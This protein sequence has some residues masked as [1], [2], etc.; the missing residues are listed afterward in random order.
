VSS[1]FEIE[2]EITLHALEHR[3]PIAEVPVSYRSRPPGS[4]SK[5]RTFRD[6]I[7]VLA[8]IVRLYKD[9]RPLQF[10]GLPGLLLFL[11]GIAVGLVVVQEFLETGR[12]A[13]I[14]RAVFAVFSCL[15]GLVATATG[16]ILETVNRRTRELYLLIADQIITSGATRDSGAV[17][18][19]KRL[20][21]E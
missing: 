5:L 17:K 16:L 13:G 21:S 7:R 6:G 19:S 10:F 8:T 14:A 12:V 1:G 15:F 2:T 9:Y 3:S 4:I 18:R 20:L 11:V